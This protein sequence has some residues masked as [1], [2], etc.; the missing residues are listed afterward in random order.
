MQHPVY[1]EIEWNAPEFE[2]WIMSLP[3]LDKI[4]VM[5]TLYSMSTS[6]HHPW[7]YWRQIQAVFHV[8]VGRKTNLG[9]EVYT[10]HH[11]SNPDEIQ[12][13][14]TVGYFGRQGVPF[15]T[16]NLLMFGRLNELQSMGNIEAQ[17]VARLKKG[18]AAWT[19]S[20]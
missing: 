13:V 3:S 18:V 7:K 14:F 12:L 16:I 5:T 9:V 19:R 17:A 8:K 10:A 6:R 15:G 20:Q 4:A 2:A 11:P 1:W